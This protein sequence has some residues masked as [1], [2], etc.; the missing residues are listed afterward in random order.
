MAF[1]VMLAKAYD[2]KRIVDWKMMYAEPKLDGVRVIITVDLNKEK[3]SYFSRNGRKLLMFTHMN[4]EVLTF[5]ERCA[6]MN[7]ASEFEDGCMLDGEM[8]NKDGDF[9]AIGGAIHT[10]EHTQVDARFS[11]FHAM[12]LEMFTKKGE[13]DQVMYLRSRMVAEIV[14]RERFAFIKW[15]K[16]THVKSDSDV[17]DAYKS[18]RKDKYEGTIVKDY[19]QP[20]IAKRSFAWMKIKGEKTEDVIV[21]GL[22]EGT[23]KYKKMVGSLVCDYKGKKIHVSGMDD[24][25]RRRWW[26][27]PESIVGL[28]IEVTG[29][30][31]TVHGAIRHPRFKRLRL[32]KQEVA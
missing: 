21:T 11:C 23:G 20:W 25:S 30:E 17:V 29:Q 1:E 31:D 16:P 5:A 19:N 13:D 6:R 9:G 7:P 14:R 28:M 27:N 2:P 32:D 3:I 22:K 24:K 12:P 4:R 26:R 10:K 18:H 15:H 8:T